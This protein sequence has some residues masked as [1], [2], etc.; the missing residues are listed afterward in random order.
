MDILILMQKKKLGG[1]M[2]ICYLGYDFFYSC[3][4]EIFKLENIEVI[5]IFTFETDNKYNFNCNIEKIAKEN[6]VPIKYSRIT[7]EDI[8]QL[9]QEGCE[10]LISA[11][12]EYKIP[13]FPESKIKQINIHP[14]LLPIGR[15]PWPLPY[16]ILK[17]L[18]KSGVTIHKISDEM[19]KG[20]ILI[21]EEFEIQSNEDIETISCKSQII[22][23]KLIIK[24]IKNLDYY[25]KNATIQGKGE[26]WPFPTVEQM[27]FTGEMTIN[28]IDRI[29]RAYGKMDS[30][31]YV[32]GEEILVHDIN[33]WREKHNYKLGKI[34]HKTN[35]EYVMAV[36]DGF[37]V[38]RYFEK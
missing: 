25:Y 30:I 9:I 38:L 6:D 23:K 17:D 15:G 24:L 5:K 37:L 21:Q 35:R 3:L 8:E 10:L 16:I 18:K 1:V 12:Y 20:D 2:K 36:A 14:T 27:T 28:E 32:D 29:V 13:V 34:V 11:G 4:E 26:Y 19:D 31:V 7:K 33:Y 22:A